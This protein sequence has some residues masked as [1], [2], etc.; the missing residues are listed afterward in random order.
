MPITNIEALVSGRVWKVE[1]STGQQV[2]EGVVVPIVE[3]M[4][5]E[6]PHEASATGTLTVLV[7]QGD[8]VKEG[9]VLA[10]VSDSFRLH[11][12]HSHKQPSRD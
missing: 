9:Q 2:G 10:T 3:S 12:F 4:K 5:M 7:A 1:Q 6:I 11:P 8:A